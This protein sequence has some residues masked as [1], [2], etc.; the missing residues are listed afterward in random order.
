MGLSVLEM[1]LDGK[2][3]SSKIIEYTTFYNLTKNR[4]TY[5]SGAIDGLRLSERQ[6]EFIGESGGGVD[7][8]TN[9]P[10]TLDDIR[11]TNNHF[12]CFDYILEHAEEPVTEE[13]L[14]QCH[15]IMKKDTYSSSREKAGDFK[16]R[17]NMVGQIATTDP[18]QVVQEL[19]ELL[20]EYNSKT[21]IYVEDVFFFHCDFIKIS[22]FPDCNG[23]IARLIMFKECLRLGIRPI[24]IDDIEKT[25]YHRVLKDCRKNRNM[26]MELCL[27]AQKRYNSMVALYQ[28]KK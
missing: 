22:P 14:R 3:S 13:M 8:Y 20:E 7:L 6:V 28:K 15:R 23:R 19:S 11:E 18:D 2:S 10:I 17:K 1:L 26:S 24:I 9:E 5:H 27:R 16:I 4:I 25:Y 21:K 12:A